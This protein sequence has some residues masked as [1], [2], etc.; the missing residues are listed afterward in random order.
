MQE[1]I[2]EKEEADN[3]FDRCFEKLPKDLKL[4][5]SKQSFLKTIE[6]HSLLNKHSNVLEIGCFIGD[7]LFHIKKIY[8][9]DVYGLEPSTKAADYCYSK[10]NIK[11]ENC[12]LINSKLNSYDKNQKIFNLII[13]DDVLSWMDRRNILSV[14]AL[15]DKILIPGGHIIIRD[16]DPTFS[17]SYQNHHVKN[18][19]VSNFKIAGGHKKFFLLSGMYAVIEENIKSEK[20]LQKINTSRLDSMNWNETLIRKTHLNLFPELPL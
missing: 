7:L 5:E 17:F 11:L 18:H 1:D 2:Y 20:S 13:L 12:S 14:V 19:K 4:R 15:I 6:K 8:E 10:F 3:F 9:C 16:F